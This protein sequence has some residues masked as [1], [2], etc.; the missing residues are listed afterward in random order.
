MGAVPD[1]QE[2][3]RLHLEGTAKLR[4]LVQECERL[5]KAGQLNEARRIFR[6]AEVLRRQLEALE[7]ACRP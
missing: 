7:E 2:L 3:F 1:L 6:R 5:H 4:E